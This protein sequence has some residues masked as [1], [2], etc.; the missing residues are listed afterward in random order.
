VHNLHDILE[1][2]NAIRKRFDIRRKSR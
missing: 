1:V 2:G